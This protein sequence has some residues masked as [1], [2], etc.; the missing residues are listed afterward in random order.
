[1]TNNFIIYLLSLIGFVPVTEEPINK[2]SRRTRKKE[3]CQHL[4]SSDF[5]VS[6]LMVNQSQA[7]D[8]K[9]GL[10]VDV[11]DIQAWLSRLSRMTLC[12]IL[13]ST[14]NEYP[15]VGDDICHRHY[16][17]TFKSQADEN[18]WEEEEDLLVMIQ[19]KARNISHQL[20]HLRPSEQFGKAHKVNH[21]LQAL[22]RSLPIHGHDSFVTLFSLIV[23]GKESLSAPT[24]VRQHLF[25]DA[26]LGRIL[27]LELASL[28]KNFKPSF[29]QSHPS[30]SMD[31]YYWSDIL[32]QEQSW[33]SC[34]QEVCSKLSRYD[35]TWE[36][37]NEY[38]DVLIIAERYHKSS[39][40]Y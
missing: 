2:K 9:D 22:I 14:I 11:D 27:I 8:E 26:K 40:L 34:L 20:D 36:Y 24:E 10:M 13:T 5:V 39:Y 25:Y 1:M 31:Q 15:Q 29:R 33:L 3:A 19:Q 4:N 7:Y 28:L 6:S 21:Q 35:A 12:Q 17:K 18:Q 23:L 37:R 38:Q 32:K 30:I 16:K